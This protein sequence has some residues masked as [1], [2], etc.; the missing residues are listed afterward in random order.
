V[1]VRPG[2]SIAAYTLWVIGAEDRAIGNLEILIR[3]RVG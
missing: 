3:V 1:P 2:D